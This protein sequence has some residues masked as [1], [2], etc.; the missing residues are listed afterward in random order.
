MSS[1]NIFNIIFWNRLLWN[2]VRPL[3]LPNKI[4]FSFHCHLFLS[5]YWNWVT[6]LLYDTTKPVCIFRLSLWVGW[7]SVCVSTIANIQVFVYFCIYSDWC[8]YL[9]SSYSVSFPSPND[10]H[11]LSTER[12]QKVVEDQNMQLKVTKLNIPLILR[13]YWQTDRRTDI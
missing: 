10:Y 11:N 9:H 2:R 7:S 1:P 12:T 4:L 3:R 13:S 6:M 5:L 8:L